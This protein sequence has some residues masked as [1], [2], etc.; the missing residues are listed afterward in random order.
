MICGEWQCVTNRLRCLLWR[1]GPDWTW[2][3][4]RFCL[5]RWGGGF[6]IVFLR[7][8]NGRCW[9]RDTSTLQWIPSWILGFFW[10]AW[11]YDGIFGVCKT[12]QLKHE[13]ASEFKIKK[14]GIGRLYT[15]SLFKYCT[16]NKNACG[17]S[18]SPASR[19]LK[20]KFH[21]CKALF[22]GVWHCIV[23]HSIGRIQ[24]FL[25]VW[26]GDVQPE[27]GDARCTRC[28]F[29]Q[30]PNQRWQHIY[31]MYIDEVATCQ[32][33]FLVSLIGGRWHI[34]PQLAVYTTYILPSG[35]LYATYHLSR[36]TRNNHWTCFG[37]VFDNY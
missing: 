7:G 16:R 2:A 33:L 37:D 6:V 24:V 29:T 27:T 36:G 11:W 22:W 18:K 5:C 4:T 1:D 12:I 28:T 3:T 19:I 9:R 25:T 15:E 8:G 31:I 32:W 21:L 10:D 13:D 35:G 14:G 26:S 17:T 34:I 30:R 23:F 20:R